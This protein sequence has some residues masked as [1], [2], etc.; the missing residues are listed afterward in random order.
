MLNLLNVTVPER[1]ERAE[2]TQERARL[3]ALLHAPAEQIIQALS[4]LDGPYWA[5]WTPSEARALGT[6]AGDLVPLGAGPQ[7]NEASPA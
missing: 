1:A 6:I 4:A 5:Q 7:R 3:T 2:F